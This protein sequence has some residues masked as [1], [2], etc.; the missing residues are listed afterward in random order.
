MQYILTDRNIRIFAAGIVYLSKCGKEITFE[1][2]SEGVTLRALNDTK[3]AF[4]AVHFQRGAC[5]APAPVPAHPFPLR[6]PGKPLDTASSRGHA[7]QVCARGTCARA[8]ARAMGVQIFSRTS[9]MRPRRTSAYVSASFWPRYAARATTRPTAE[10]SYFACADTR[11]L[12]PPYRVAAA[13]RSAS[14]QDTT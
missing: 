13:E 3:S 4:A 5:A 7:L 1:G 9:S 12:L 2:T 6:T 11:L 8:R 14:I 10:L